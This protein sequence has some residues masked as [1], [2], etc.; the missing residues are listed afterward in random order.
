MNKKNYIYIAVAAVALVAI[1]IMAAGRAGGNDSPQRTPGVNGWISNELSDTSSLSGLDRKIRYFMQE[2][3]IKGLSLSVMR[4]DSLLYAKGY[5]WADEEA[6]EKMEPYHLLRLASISKLVTAAGLMVLQE[7]GKLSLSDT[8]FGPRG[9]LPEYSSVIRDRNYYKITVEDL[10]RHKGGFKVVGGDPMFAT[11]SIMRQ[12][13]LDHVPS[14]DELLRIVLARKLSFLPG[15]SQAY[16][17]LGYLILSLVIEKVSGQP[18]EEFIQENVLRPA[19]C[20]D[21]HI[22]G[23]YRSDAHPREVHYYVPVNEPP[24]PEFNCSGDTVVRCYGG[25]NIPALSGAGAWVA[26]TPEVARFVA[27][28]D[29]RGI[30]PDII[31]K[32]S[33][34]YMVEYFDKETYSLGWNDTEPSSGWMRSGTFS[35]TSALIRYFPDG[36]CWVLV[37]NTSTWKGPGLSRYIT[38]LFKD[39]RE[40]Y[41]R[42]LPERNLF[43]NQ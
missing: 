11:R 42:V 40:K 14:S 22:A 10:M 18:Y 39:L 41:S 32:E 7:Q 36:E 24:V 28:I 26:S 20:M 1:I 37:T 27:A 3:Q 16:S 5:G 34:D 21:F 19:G 12:N 43:E 23:N 29:A 25:N 17:N 15:T 35:G 9:I 4:G 13:G 8:V 33:V 31:S 30:L 2:W 38:T 6:Q